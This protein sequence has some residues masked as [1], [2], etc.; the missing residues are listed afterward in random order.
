[1]K[2]RLKGG[3]EGV[4]SR[5][6]S[7]QERKDARSARPCSEREDR[8]ISG[9]SEPCQLEKW[10]FY[11]IKKVKSSY[12][13]SRQMRKKGED[14]LYGERGGGKHKKKGEILN[15]CGK[16]LQEGSHGSRHFPY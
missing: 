12:H 11:L 16:T 3:E 9:L 7:G 1:V 6:P 4:P 5:A 8:R 2:P 10:G 13:G 15:H 14:G